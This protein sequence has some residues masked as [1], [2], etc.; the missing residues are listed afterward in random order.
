MPG[1]M[2]LP[3]SVIILSGEGGFPAAGFVLFPHQV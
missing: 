2:T 3:R 1:V